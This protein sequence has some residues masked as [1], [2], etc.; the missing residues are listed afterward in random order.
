MKTYYVKSNANQQVRAI[1][2]FKGKSQTIQYNFLPWEEDNGS[3]TSVV[4]SVKSGDA[5]VSN[6]SLSSSIASAVITTA[7]AGSSLITLTATAGNNVE[8]LTLRVVAK[9]PEYRIHDYGICE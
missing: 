2:S 3:V 4:W 7:N 1:L 5:S 8:V 6:E 9:D